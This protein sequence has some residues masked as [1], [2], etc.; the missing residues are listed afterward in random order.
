MDPSLED[1]I[2]TD[3]GHATVTAT[4]INTGGKKTD[5]NKTI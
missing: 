2:F 3:D 4:G 1:S 5:A